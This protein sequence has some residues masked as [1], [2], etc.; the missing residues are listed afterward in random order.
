MTIQ[1]VQ[2]LCYHSFWNTV[3]M[4]HHGNTTRQMEQTRYPY[5]FC[6]KSGEIFSL[7]IQKLIASYNITVESIIKVMRIT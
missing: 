1:E 6:N 4:V 3:L 7:A 5:K 2:I